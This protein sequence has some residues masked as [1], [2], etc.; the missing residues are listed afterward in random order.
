M[1]AGEERTLA[2]D[3]LTE[4]FIA[5]ALVQGPPYPWGARTHPELRS[6]AEF[7]AH[8]IRSGLTEKTR[9]V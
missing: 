7:A 8:Q 3:P 2:I 6:W 4:L 1:N 9:R 5:N